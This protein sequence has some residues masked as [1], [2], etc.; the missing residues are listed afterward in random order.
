MSVLPEVSLAHIEKELEEARDL[1]ESLELDLDTSMLSEED[2]RF[3]VSGHAPDNELYIVEFSCDNYREFPP[4]VEMIDP[5][6]GEAGV[7]RAYPKGIF[8]NNQLCICARFNRKSY[9]EYSGIHSGWEYG[10]WKQNP[11]ADH[12][13]GM[14]SHIFRAIDGRMQGRSYQGRLGE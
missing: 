2:L 11:E 4:L 3:R 10:D 8:H 9:A 6:S 12:L 7:K 14:I 13:G 5:E 1:I